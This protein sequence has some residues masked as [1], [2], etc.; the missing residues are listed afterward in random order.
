MTTTETKQ[1]QADTVVFAGKRN[2]KELAW[3][4]SISARRTTEQ[5]KRLR[6][7]HTEMMVNNDIN[8]KLKLNTGNTQN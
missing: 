6:A 3:F 2:A 8:T 4:K 5:V 7:Y 1:V